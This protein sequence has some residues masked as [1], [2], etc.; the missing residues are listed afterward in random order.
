MENISAFVN[1]FSTEVI[2]GAYHFATKTQSD[3]KYDHDDLILLL[4]YQNVLKEIKIQKLITCIEEVS[5]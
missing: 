3:M 1:T 2:E 4:L 5:K